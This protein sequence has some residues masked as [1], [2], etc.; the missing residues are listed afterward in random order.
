MRA[1]ALGKLTQVFLDKE[2]KASL[3]KISGS[4]PVSYSSDTSKL[5]TIPLTLNE[6]EILLS[7]CK[8][9]PRT[10]QQAQDLL[11]NVVS[12]YF[13]ESY[14]Q[15]FT[16]VLLNKYKIDGLKNPV[17][18]LTMEL[19]N[20]LIRL[21]DV[22]PQLEK[23]VLCLVDTYLESVTATSKLKL[24]G[25]LSLVGFIEAF[26]SQRSETLSSLHFC[27]CQ[28]LQK[29]VDKEFL[30]RVEDVLSRSV[31]NDVLIDYFDSG[32]EICPFLFCALVEKFQVAVVVNLLGVPSDTSLSEY[33]LNLQDWEFR[34]EDRD[35][36]CIFKKTLGS[37]KDILNKMISYSLQ[38]ILQFEN[39]AEYI[40]FTSLHRINL[41]FLAKEY[42]LQI[43]SLSFFLKGVEDE[44]VRHVIDVVAD[45]V[46]DL[47]SN[48][49]ISDSTLLETVISVASLM[50]FFTEEVSSQLLHVFPILVS[51][52]QISNAVVSKISSSF[53][54]GLQPLTEDAVVGTIY[55]INNL[56]AVAEDGSLIPVYKERKMTVNGFT[57]NDTNHID[58]LLASRPARSNTVATYQSLQMVKRSNSE[59]Q[60]AQG[61]LQLDNTTNNDGVSSSVASIARDPGSSPTMYHDMLFKNAVTATTT[62]A[63]HY[64][65]QS[66][67]ALTITILTQKFR[68]VSPKLDQII[69]E[70]LAH[71]AIA[72]NQTEF[73][74]LTKFYNSAVSSALKNNDTSLFKSIIKAET[75]ISRDL[76]TKQ[77]SPLYKIYLRNLL[78]TI[79][80]KGEVDK[81]E[82]HRSHSEISQVAEQIATY[83]KPLA[84]LLPSPGSTPLDLSLD[85]TTTNMF[86]NIWF[87]MVVHGFHATSELAVKNHSYL[88]TIAYNSP[89]LASDFPANNRETSLEMNTILRRGS[90]NHNVREQKHA[91]NGYLPANSMASR[92]L[93]T[94]KVMFLASTAFLENLR[95]ESGDC[96]K[97]LLYLSDPSIVAS[98]MDRPIA[99]IS[100][101][102]VRRFTKFIVKS[103]PR[104]FSAQNIAQQLTNILLLSTHRDQYLQDAAFQCCDIFIKKVPSSLCHH[105]SLYTLLDLLTTL[106]ESIVDCE[107]KKYEPRFEFMLKHSKKNILVPDSYQWRRSSL[108]RLHKFA[109]DWV[110]TV[111]QRS[112]QDMKILLQS[113]M[114]DLGSFHRLNS[115][116][117]GVSFALEMAGTILSVDREL[118]KI[119]YHGYEKPDTVSGF[120]SQHSWR[121]S[122]LMENG[123]ISSHHEIDTERMA[124]KTRIDSQ[125]SERAT[126]NQKDV[127]KFLDLSAS[128]LLLRKGESA[129]LV[130]DLVHTPFQVFTSY[131]IKIATNIWLSVI[132]E[133]RDLAHLLISEV[134][135]CWMHSIDENVGLFSKKLDL[136]P[137]EFQT[138]EY[139]PYNKKHINHCSLVASKA[140]QPHLHIIRF[141]SSHFEG[142]LFESKHLLNIFTKLSLHG[143]VNLQ[144]ASLHP[145]ARITR[146]ELLNFQLLVLRANI[147]YNTKEVP[148]I[149][150][151]IVDGA[152]SW[153]KAAPSWPFGSNE[154]KIKADLSL[155]IEFYTQLKS[156]ETVLKNYSDNHFALLQYFM[157]SEIR[158]LET[159]LD[160]L[161]KSSDIPKL[162]EMLITVAFNKDPVL[163]VNIVERYSNST[164][165][166]DEVLMQLI[167][168]APLTCVHIPKALEYLL[169][170]VEN[171]THAK[172]GS[173]L[174]NVLYWNPISPVKSI[175][176]FLPTW[177]S[178]TF[179]I[180]YN[181]R[182][183]ESHDVNLTFFYVPQ[184]VQ[185]LR[186]DSTGYVERFIL[187]TAK[188]SV[189]FSHQIIWNMLA[190]CY[191]G[192]DGLIEDDIKPT[193]DR[194]REKMISRFDDS[195]KSFYQREFGFFNEVTGISGK[196]KPYIKKTKA[197]KKVKIDEEMANIV[198]EKD[199]YLPSN[200][201]GV[202]VDID[203]LSGK[204][205]Q[206]HAKAPFM[207]TFKIKKQVYN[208]ETDE[209]EHLEKWQAAIFKVGDDCRQ[210]VLA[211]QLISV[212]R[213]IWSNIGLDVYVFPY[214]VTATAPGC[215]VI[216]VLPNSISRDMLGR[217]AV[218]GLYEYF[219]TK[220]GHENT[221]AFQ[222]ARN[223]FVKSLA[224]YSVISYLLQFKDRHNGN[225]MYD[226]Q[227]H[228]LHIDF[229]F[230]FDI[231]PG[232]VKFEAVPFKLTKEMVKV[233]GGS[234]D[235]QAYREFEELC[236]KAYLA[237][238][239]HMDTILQCVMP[240][241]ESGLPCFKG[242]KTVKNLQARFAPQRTAHDAAI[243]MKA[244]IKR[245]YES[246]FTKGYDEFQRLTNGIPY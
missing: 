110:K 50:N 132:K 30:V 58:R 89:P 88:K 186:Y 223:N 70:E 85:E 220:F 118:S 104:I 207:A 63:S 136:L 55:S 173:L 175:N 154:L 237:A 181:V 49:V 9:T 86:R 206:S 130:Y 208:D 214:R 18:I 80:S 48:N 161:N 116:E 68:V 71:L 28:K 242:L 31:T 238:R 229:G 90:S 231:V 82:H 73:S 240:M 76:K 21:Q 135:Y 124:I 230:I 169:S 134:G 192:D 44:Q 145:F 100:V 212:F 37:N 137:E 203:R 29:I 45:A 233:M 10:L 157:L 47:L 101:S 112:N 167:M 199:V 108:E 25:L 171:S 211:L 217:E 14:Q 178:N 119:S 184:I 142:S 23:R 128:L 40:S 198:V 60:S 152:L 113:Y 144:K 168:K 156:N 232:G 46:D 195:Q 114:S 164:K 75:T 200:P 151:A 84:A 69:L 148:Q 78:D 226:D 197:E 38:Q 65:D 111:L 204:P 222:N 22:F 187:D 227:G 93:S 170:F 34:D 177:K 6:L 194:I 205:L 77:S 188:I 138:M 159:W 2:D 15:K 146:T 121:C 81:L 166:L 51:S 66:I 106:F 87:N 102:M 221:I 33:L 193:L 1:K 12:N 150:R 218:N 120:L 244:L 215:G 126:V 36:L 216:D 174:H 179:V 210:D 245:S 236:I 54:V 32:R 56:L 17:E 74:M 20:F 183:L 190:N 115:V 228:C 35:E 131:A 196:L 64:N 11:D 139:S 141:F 98:S 235:T 125:L 103:D 53:S 147:Q 149:T 41:A 19:T 79:I 72:V 189:L 176:L 224:A 202:V 225:I 13:L 83:L 129:A 234:P 241:L 165:R 123:S 52:Q 95:C 163:A 24:N 117:F 143:T 97:T 61:S 209:I 180:Q 243:H 94:P 155:L 107:T 158:T 201:D 246:M 39:G 8:S 4:L 182:A 91:I 153:F 122:F 213:T 27:I 96:S 59:S 26:A 191:K 3:D 185:C 99:S 57:N 140:I 105:D 92:T 160:P 7:L 133:R 239:P 162:P 219:V 127:A 5:Y 42:A 172:D 62:I 67:T 43:I 109:R 16:D